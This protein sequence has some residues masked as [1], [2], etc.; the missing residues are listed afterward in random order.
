[1]I[2]FKQYLNE[3]TSK[4]NRLITDLRRALDS[5]V[6]TAH[7]LNYI[8][9]A[10]WRPAAPQFWVGRDLTNLRKVLSVTLKPD[11]QKTARV[12]ELDVVDTRPKDGPLGTHQFS[13]LAVVIVDPING[14]MIAVPS[15][16]KPHDYIRSHGQ[17]TR[18]L[19]HN[20]P[21]SQ[22]L[23]KPDAVRIKDI[24]KAAT[25]Q[26]TFYARNHHKIKRG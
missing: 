17:I 12:F 20:D 5:S 3:I 21:R 13:F 7:N 10:T 4:Q 24:V 19:M 8:T 1:M 23:P 11:L 14:D 9:S 15:L 26:L 25:E 2:S 16:H 22:I 6:R 18:P